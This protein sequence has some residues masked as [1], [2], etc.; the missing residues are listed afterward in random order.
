MNVVHRAFPQPSKEG[1]V[2]IIT[3][4]MRRLELKKTRNSGHPILDPQNGP[5]HSPL[6]PEGLMLW[7]VEPGN[8]SPRLSQRGSRKPV[9]SLNIVSPLCILPV[10]LIFG[11]EIWL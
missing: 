5:L 7:S 11:D 10:A 4:Q 1:A 3:V 9:L 2:T 6:I 8:G